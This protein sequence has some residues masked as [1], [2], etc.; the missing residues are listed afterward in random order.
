MHS[1]DEGNTIA[2]LT[3][4]GMDESFNAVRQI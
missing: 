1:D 3:L 4:H 2:A